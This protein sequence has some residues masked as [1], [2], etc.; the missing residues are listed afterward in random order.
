MSTEWEQR[1]QAAVRDLA[2]TVSAPLVTPCDVRSDD[3][4]E[5]GL[6]RIVQAFG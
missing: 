5:R 4:L 1:V 6:D 2:E 3:D